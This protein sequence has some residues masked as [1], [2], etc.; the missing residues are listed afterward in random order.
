MPFFVPIFAAVGAGLVAATPFIAAAGLG[1]TAY[2]T[3]QQVS[4]AKRQAS[5]QREIMVQEQRAE[6]VRMRAMELDARRRQLEVIRNQQRARAMALSTATAQGAGL[7]SGLFGG[8]GQ[9]SGQTGTN[10]LGIS[11]NLGLGQQM[12][13][14]NSAIS[15]S[16]IGMAGAASSAVTGAGLSSLGGAFISAMPYL[17]SLGGSLSSPSSGAYKTTS[18]PA[19][20]FPQWSPRMQGYFSEF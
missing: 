18:S 9:I 20:A 12:F 11:Q 17:S 7:G 2:G 16:K 13:G 14:I 4:A 10:L 8:Y 5:F 1:M 6:A 3:V 15:Q 19:Y